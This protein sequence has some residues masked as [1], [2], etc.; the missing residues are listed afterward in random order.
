MNSSSGTSEGGGGG[1]LGAD[2]PACGGG[3]GD[4]AAAHTTHKAVPRTSQYFGENNGH[5]LRSWLRARGFVR[6]VVEIDIVLQ[7]IHRIAGAFV[8]RGNKVQILEG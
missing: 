5:H 1:R 2:F 3:A 7:H 8:A 4:C 6:P